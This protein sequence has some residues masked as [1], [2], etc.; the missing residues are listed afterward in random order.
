MSGAGAGDAGDAR[1]KAGGKAGGRAGTARSVAACAGWI[2]LSMSAGLAAAFWPVDA[3]YATLAKPAWNPPNW[4]FG[5]VWTTLYILIGVA[6][7]RVARTGAFR[8]DRAT[9]GLFLVQWTLN[10]AWSGFFFGLHA[11][12]LAAVEIVVLLA[13][14][15]ATIAR[16]ARHDRVAAILLAPYGA[17]VGFATALNLAIW[18]LN[19]G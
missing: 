19:R 17:W 14:V 12:G 1:G 9:L 15:L 18:S 6:A 3:W 16:F 7:W 10:F 4:L 11:P 8:R 13:L 5:P 2:A